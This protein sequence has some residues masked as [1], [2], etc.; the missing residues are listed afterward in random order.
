MCWSTLSDYVINALDVLFA[1][2]CEGSGSEPKLHK[3][4][5]PIQ[6]TSKAH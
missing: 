5:S 2:V 1:V 4:Y 6:S 3:K